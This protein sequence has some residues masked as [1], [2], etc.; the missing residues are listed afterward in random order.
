VEVRQYL[1]LPGT[2]RSVSDKPLERHAESINHDARVRIAE[3]LD[4][5][6]AG[7]LLRLWYSCPS[8]SHKRHRR[9]SKARRPSGPPDFI[10]AFIP[11][12]LSAPAQRLKPDQS[13]GAHAE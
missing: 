5:F 13:L 3:A 10:L 7:E 12:S 6:D 11:I 4:D 2:D 9:P 1:V 8:G